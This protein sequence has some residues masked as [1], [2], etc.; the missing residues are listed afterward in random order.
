[1]SDMQAVLESFI[2]AQDDKL[3]SVESKTAEAIQKF[4]GQ[5][6]DKGK[7]DPEVKSEVRELTEQFKSLAASVNDIAQKQSSIAA[8]GGKREMSAAEEFVSSEQFKQFSA[9][10]TQ[11]VRM[12][13]KNTVTSGSTTVFPQQNPGIITGDFKPLTVRQILRSVPTSSNMVNSLREA[14]WTNSAAF[15]SQGATKPE[16][17]VTFEAYN[18]AIE[19]VA[20]TIKMSNQLMADAP[21]VVAYIQT[22]LRDGLAQK[23]EAQLITGNG[24]APNLS[25][26]TDSGNYTAYT[27]TSD[28]LLVDA[29]NRAKY[30]LWSATG[31]MPDAVIVNPA[32]WAAME[33]TREGGTSGAYLYGLPGT[34]AGVNPFGV[35]VVLSNNVAADKF[36]IGAMDASAVLYARQG[37][38]IE[39]GFVNDDF[40]KNLVTARCEERLGLAVE[41]PSCI[42]YGSFTA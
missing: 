11:R 22:R 28:D 21:A 9:G 18:V 20:H 24:T 37:A 8:N 26:L 13:V 36:I 27:P 12:E 1:M 41:R 39:F 35:R 4:E 30:A 31:Q 40:A 34:M 23:I 16:S 3:K 6:A 32:T 19:T 17:D 29:I 14:S 15:I 25:G 10:N 42:Y 2:K 33:R 5:L 38:V 7:V